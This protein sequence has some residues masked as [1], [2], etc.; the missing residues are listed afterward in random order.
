MLADAVACASRSRS[1][2]EEVDVGEI[3]VGPHRTELMR[4]AHA[5]DDATKRAAQLRPFQW[6]RRESNPPLYQALCL[7][8]RRFTSSRSGSV[9]LVTCGFV[10]RS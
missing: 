10:L 1:T 7:L 3:V 2:S 6:R 5:D 4:G 8:T 9:P